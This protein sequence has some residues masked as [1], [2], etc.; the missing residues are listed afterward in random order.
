MNGKQFYWL[1]VFEQFKPV[2][3]SQPV[4]QDDF[5]EPRPIVQM[6]AEKW[7]RSGTVNISPGQATEDV[8][9]DIVTGCK[10]GEVPNDA[11]LIN[12]VMLPN[13]LC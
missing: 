8:V 12:L 11:L 10:A 4:E 3:V 5:D 2:A 9:K 1:A 13:R 6:V 7:N